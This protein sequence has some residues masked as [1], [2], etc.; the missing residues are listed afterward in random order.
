MKKRKRI[1]S[2]YST[3]IDG[4][5]YDAYIDLHGFMITEAIFHTTK[6]LQEHPHSSLMIIHG[7]GSGALRSKIR[8]MLKSGK[9]PCSTF[10][11]GEDIGAPGSDGVTIVFT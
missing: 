5:S 4:T 9:L 10:F 7:N 8:S 3:P 1:S 2:G 11:P 6:F